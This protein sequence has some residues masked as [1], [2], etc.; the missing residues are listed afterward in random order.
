MLEVLRT[1]AF[2]RVVALLSSFTTTAPVL[3]LLLAVVLLTSPALAL[4]LHKL[5]FTNTKMLS[6]SS[7]PDKQH[8]TEILPAMRA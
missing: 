7:Q 2:E 8:Q 5:F 4:L 3:L 1:L 6:N